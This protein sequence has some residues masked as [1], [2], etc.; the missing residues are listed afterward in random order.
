MDNKRHHLELIQSVI[1][2]MATNSFALK[3]WVVSLMAGIF[4]LADK[5]ADK[6]YVVI[7]LIPILFFWFLDSYYLLQERL[8]RALYNKT[9][10][11]EESEIDFSMSATVAEFGDKKSNYLSCVFSLTESLFYVPLMITCAIVGYYVIH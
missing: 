11:Q 1:N 5:D 8:Y 6:Y 9:R 2:R 10:E 3:G 7:A 4:V